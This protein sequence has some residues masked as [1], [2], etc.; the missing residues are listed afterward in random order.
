MTPVVV[1][2]SSSD[3]TKGRIDSD[4]EYSFT[5]TEVDADPLEGGGDRSNGGKT[6]VGGQLS[7]FSADRGV[8]QDCLELSSPAFPN[9]GECDPDLYY[10][11]HVYQATACD[12][13]CLHPD[14]DWISLAVHATYMQAELSRLMAKL[15]DELAFFDGAPERR[16][17]WLDDDDDVEPALL[18]TIRSLVRKLDSYSFTLEEQALDFD[19]W[20]VECER[21]ADWVLLS[22]P[23]TKRCPQYFDYGIDRLLDLLGPLQS[24]AFT[25]DL[26]AL[27]DYLVLEAREFL[28]IDRSDDASSAMLGLD[29]RDDEPADGR[30]CADGAPGSAAPKKPRKRRRRRRPLAGTAAAAS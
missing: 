22:G 7:D 10:W 3:V 19:Y 17:T 9:V 15:M 12:A 8:R 23:N 24:D 26:E 4:I 30:E 5:D 16:P 13:V 27:R 14:D 1:D 11:F 18:R 29:D 25:S 20:T 21:E 6:A 28:R 2:T